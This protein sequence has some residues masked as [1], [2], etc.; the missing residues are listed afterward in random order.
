MFSI[1]LGYFLYFKRFKLTARGKKGIYRPKNIYPARETNGT[2]KLR[3]LNFRT[4]TYIL[5]SVEL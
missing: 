4:V 3:Q 5:S 2:N 1:K